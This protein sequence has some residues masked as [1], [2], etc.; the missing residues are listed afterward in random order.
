[1]KKFFKKFL[2]I[3]VLLTLF[4]VVIISV[5]VFRD[6]AAFSGLATALVVPITAYF[7]ANVA[8]DKI[9]ADRPNTESSAE[10]SGA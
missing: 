8:Q 2:S 6:L 10:K 9:Y 3:K 5:I 7:A 4:C 1:M